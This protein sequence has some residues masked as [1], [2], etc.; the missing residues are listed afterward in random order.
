MIECDEDDSRKMREGC[1]LI[2]RFFE[3]LHNIS[4]AIYLDMVLRRPWLTSMAR[5]EHRR[6]SDIA[7]LP[8]KPKEAQAVAAPQ[9]PREIKL[10]LVV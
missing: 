2:Y 7:Q 10:T 5:S 1:G 6:G 9:R 4:T 8:T 3:G